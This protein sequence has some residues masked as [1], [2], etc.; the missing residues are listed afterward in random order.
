MLEG[1]KLAFK[2][3]AAA[4]TIVELLLVI[5][6]IA[7]LAAVSVV[8]Y[9][10][11]QNRA[12]ATTLQS[13]LRNVATLLGLDKAS[14]GS[15]PLTLGNISNGGAAK[16]VG[17]TYQYTSDGTTFCLTSTSDRNIGAYNISNTSSV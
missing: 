12:A 13:D 8:A 15:Y 3:Q 4:F 14:N 10:G 11:I 6:I 16:S 9:V 7:I 1:P 17:T 5:V 2:K